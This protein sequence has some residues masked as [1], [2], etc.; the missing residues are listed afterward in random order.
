MLSSFIAKDSVIEYTGTAPLRAAYNEIREAIMDANIPVKMPIGFT[1]LSSG[2]SG[3]SAI[4]REAGCMESMSAVASNIRDILFVGDTNQYVQSVQIEGPI[5]TG[6][7]NFYS[8]EDNPVEVVDKNIYVLTST[9][10]VKVVFFVEKGCGYKTMEESARAISD[11]GYF[12]LNTSF[13]LLHY[14]HVLP[15]DGR[16]INVRY[17]KGMTSEIFNRILKGE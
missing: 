17:S 15:F 14:I 9:T 5:T 13:S 7:A 1:L 8:Q 12:P 4:E 3:V 2:S 16:A 11:K 6:N 10:K